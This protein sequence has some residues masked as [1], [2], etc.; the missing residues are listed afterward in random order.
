MYDMLNASATNEDATNL[1]ENA[2]KLFGERGLEVQSVEK[3]D[4][5]QDLFV[6]QFFVLASAAVIANYHEVY[7]QQF[8]KLRFA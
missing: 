8:S 2:S 3:T 6:A 1:L 4:C 7:C 5:A